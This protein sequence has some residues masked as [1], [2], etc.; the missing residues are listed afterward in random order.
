MNQFPNSTRACFECGSTDHLKVNCAQYKEKIERKKK[1]PCK[2]CKE[3]GHH[4]KNCDRLKRKK[5]AIA[6]FEKT[7]EFPDLC[8]FVAPTPKQAKVAWAT[9]VKSSGDEA[10]LQEVARENEYARSLIKL[11]KDRK[12]KKF[13]DRKAFKLKLKEDVNKAQQDNMVRIRGVY[14]FLY[15]E[16]TIDEFDPITELY[17]L[18][19][20][21]RKLR[22]DYEMETA[23]EDQ[24]EALYE[25]QEY[26]RYIAEKNEERERNKA[27]MTKEEYE[28]WIADD[29]HRLMDEA[30]RDYY[31]RETMYLTRVSGEYA[32]NYM[33][34]GLM[35]DPKFKS[36]KN[37]ER[38]KELR[39][40]TAAQRG[41]RLK[42]ELYRGKH[43]D[44]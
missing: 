16:D 13:E 39:L 34:C 17:D 35:V 20:I 43:D 9:I 4:I 6:K 3:L 22:Y 14:W 12:L 29:F 7:M 2:Y 24:N 23:L 37:E 25:Q 19:E 18:R 11:E 31:Q 44:L 32:Q 42:I 27:I 41:S 40:E 10:V 28:R 30:D 15:T 26:D 21:A 8:Q 5:E 33:K 36:F 1:E 38:N